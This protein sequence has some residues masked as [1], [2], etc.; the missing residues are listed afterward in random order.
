MLIL[1]L[2]I[3]VPTERQELYDDR[4]I[5]SDQFDNLNERDCEKI[6][7][8]VREFAVELGDKYGCKVEVRN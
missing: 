7:Q 4:R 1:M 6:E 8:E 2:K 5:S 3:G